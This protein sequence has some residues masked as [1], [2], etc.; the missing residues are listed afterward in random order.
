M[1]PALKKFLTKMCKQILVY[2]LILGAWNWLL[3]KPSLNDFVGVCKLVSFCFLVILSEGI[4]RDLEKEDSDVRNANYFICVVALLL[5]V[6]L[7]LKILK[8]P[9]DQIAVNEAAREVISKVTKSIT[10]LSVLPIFL[11]SL[12]NLWVGFF[13]PKRGTG[14]YAHARCYFLFADCPC[15]VPLLF[16]VVIMMLPARATGV[17]S[18]LFFNGAVTVIVF[19]SNTV[20]LALDIF[21]DDTKAKG[22]ADQLLTQSNAA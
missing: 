19:M 17:E 8:A 14:L 4:T 18:E 7:C 20:S 12:L 3:E 5:I 2:V 1:S 15:A 21:L 22:I 10:Y 6:P 16:V 11:Y 13:R 9:I